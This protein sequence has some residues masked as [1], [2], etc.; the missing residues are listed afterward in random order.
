M[1][2]E[3]RKNPRR[4]SE[5]S[6]CSER[7]LFHVQPVFDD[8]QLGHFLEIHSPAHE[9]L[10]LLYHFF[11]RLFLAGG[12]N[13][14]IQVGGI[15]KVRAAGFPRNAMKVQLGTLHVLDPGGFQLLQ[16]RL[17]HY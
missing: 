11:V 3:T 2:M 16:D 17:P 13:A 12:G 5:G 1:E 6:R 9:R 4:A 10:E 7:R 8:A 15:F 14:M